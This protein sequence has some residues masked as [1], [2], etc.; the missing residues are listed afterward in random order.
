MFYQFIKSTYQLYICISVSESVYGESCTSDEGCLTGN[1][2]CDG[3]TTT[4]RCPIDYYRNVTDETCMQSKFTVFLFS[5][6]NGSVCFSV[7]ANFKVIIY[8]YLC[9]SLF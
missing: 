8:C 2:V 9:L 3:T 7:P 4:C 5:K 1:A 6:Y